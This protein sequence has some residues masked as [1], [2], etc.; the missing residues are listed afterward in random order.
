MC[1]KYQSTWQL[2]QFT[3]FSRILFSFA[4]F[5]AND[6]SFSNLR[7]SAWAYGESDIVIISP[8]INYHF[9]FSRA[10]LLRIKHQI[11]SLNVRYNYFSNVIVSHDASFITYHESFRKYH[12]I[13]RESLWVIMS[14]SIHHWSAC[15]VIRNSELSS[16]VFIHRTLY[17]I[18]PSITSWW[19]NRNVKGK[20]RLMVWVNNGVWITHNE[21][22][23][24]LRNNDELIT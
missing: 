12:F 1:T 24:L 10:C 20:H 17:W 7:E 11:K 8:L 21:S 3:I 15:I 16:V 2:Y 22:F 6:C 9:T 18:I 5:R 13:N 23:H 19:C 14:H 4:I